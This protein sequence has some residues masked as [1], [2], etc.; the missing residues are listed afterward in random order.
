MF[1]DPWAGDHVPGSMTEYHCGEETG[2]AVQQAS[3]DAQGYVVH[4]PHAC[5]GVLAFP[6]RRGPDFVHAETVSDY[7]DK[8]ADSDWVR[9]VARTDVRENGRYDATC[10]VH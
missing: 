4:S 10:S 5:R 6:S 1:R 8:V 2:S 9:K 7:L 3:D